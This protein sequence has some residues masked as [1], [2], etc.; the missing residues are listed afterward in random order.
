MLLLHR[1]DLVLDLLV[2]VLLIIRI[3]HGRVHAAIAVLMREKIRPVAERVCR[4]RRQWHMRNIWSG[5]DTIVGIE[6]RGFQG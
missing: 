4:R 3:K 6:A 1:M 5:D 2:V